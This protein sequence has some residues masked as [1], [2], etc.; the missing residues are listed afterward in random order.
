MYYSAPTILFISIVYLLSEQVP[1]MCV[2]RAMMK[3]YN[4]QIFLQNS[5]SDLE[6]RQAYLLFGDRA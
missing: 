4:L 6:K 5:F 2:T 1:I 3:F